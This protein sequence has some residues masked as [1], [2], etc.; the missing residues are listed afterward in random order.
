MNRGLLCLSFCS[1]RLLMHKIGRVGTVRGAGT[2]ERNFSSVEQSPRLPRDTRKE[3]FLVPFAEFRSIL[4][5]QRHLPLVP[6]YLRAA[7]SFQFIIFHIIL[8]IT[9]HLK[10]ETLK[11]KRKWRR[12]LVL[13]RDTTNWQLSQRLSGCLFTKDVCST[14]IFLLQWSSS[15]FDVPVI[16]D[17]RNGPLINSPIYVVFG[18]ILIATISTN[19]WFHVGE[20]QTEMNEIDISFIACSYLT[21]AS[22]CRTVSSCLLLQFVRDVRRYRL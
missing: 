4:Q 9:F 5:R 21:R 8:R 7:D 14:W 19:H 17:H 11:S 20:S 15:N 1:P 2:S 22:L 12:P 6:A 10:N 18:L 16:G 3:I 13:A